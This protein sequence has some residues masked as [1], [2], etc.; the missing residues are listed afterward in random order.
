MSL[1]NRHHFDLSDPALRDQHGLRQ[2]PPAETVSRP[3]K[4]WKRQKRAYVRRDDTKQAI[5]D[6]LGAADAPLSRR[7]IVEGIGRS[8]CPYLRDV[9]A[10]MVTAG[11]I[12][13]RES[14]YRHLPMFVY[15]VAP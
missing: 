12:I 1:P 9:I 14:N 5:L 8:K 6:L 7:E 13:E 2:S 4:W 15:E 11:Q 3:Y 10:E